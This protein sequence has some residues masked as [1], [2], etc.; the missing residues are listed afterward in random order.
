MAGINEFDLKASGWD[1]K[2]ERHER[3][4]AIAKEMLRLL[5]LRKGMRAMEYGAGTG[6]LSF[7]LKDYFDEILLMDSSS[8]MVKVANKKIEA[9]YARNLKPVFFDLEHEIYSGKSFDLIFSQMVMHHLNDIGSISRKFFQMLKP[10][11]YL[12]VADL[13][14]EDGSFHG[15]GFTGH[16]GFDIMELKSLL[17]ECR[18]KT[19]YAEQCYVIKKVNSRGEMSQ[20]P[21]FLI[22]ASRD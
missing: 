8:E 5:P 20:F 10:G 18:F 9:A 12:A 1:E 6:I 17:N 19:F 3:S 7:L 11:G 13:Y 22:V 21:V 4:E 2:P 14:S 16:K 15:E